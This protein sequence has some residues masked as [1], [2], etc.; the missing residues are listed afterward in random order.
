MSRSHLTS[1]DEL[2]EDDDD[3]DEPEDSQNNQ[4]HKFG[5]TSREA[6]LLQLDEKN[7]NEITEI[8][9]FFQDLVRWTLVSRRA[10]PYST[11][12]VGT[13]QSSFDLTSTTLT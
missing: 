1:Y 2:D 5:T 4:E 3:E 8:H 10:L 6:F 7:L 11:G 12:I 13:S 9:A